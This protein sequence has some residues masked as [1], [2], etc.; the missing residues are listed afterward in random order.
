MK[1]LIHFNHVKKVQKIFKRQNGKFT[2]EMSEIVEGPWIYVN[3]NPKQQCNK[4]RSIQFKCFKMIP[5]ECMDCYKVVVR[6]RTVVEL[7]KLLDL[8]QDLPKDIHCKCGIEIRPY[9][10]ALYGGYFYTFSKKAG[11]ARYKEVRKLVDEQISPDVKVFLKRACTEYEMKYGDSSKWELNPR[12]REIS[13]WIDKN[14]DEKLL[15]GAAEQ[16]GELKIDT[17]ERW[18]EYAATNADKTYLELTDGEPMYDPPVIYAGE[19]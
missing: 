5:K 3:N 1:K 14:F 9:V 13:A 10:A 11:R 4:W 6:P 18:I 8:Q 16:W 17:A 7:F 12:E 19:L 15:S 2:A